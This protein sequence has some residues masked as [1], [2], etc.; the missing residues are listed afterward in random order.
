MPVTKAQT[1]NPLYETQFPHIYAFAFVLGHGEVNIPMLDRQG[2]S[3]EALQE[4]ENVLEGMSFR[5]VVNYSKSQDTPTPK[6]LEPVI[7]FL[8]SNH[9]LPDW[10]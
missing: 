8:K 3:E 1:L 4:M 2:L 7:S 9:V 10:A 6:A 5:S